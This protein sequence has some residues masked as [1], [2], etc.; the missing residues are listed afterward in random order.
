MMT[1]EAKRG[2]GRPDEWIGEGGEARG[3]QGF[4]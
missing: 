4:S 3:Q 2:S 1:S